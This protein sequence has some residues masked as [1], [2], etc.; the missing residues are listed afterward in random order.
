MHDANDDY[1]V[2]IFLAD[3][4]SETKFIRELAI[5]QLYHHIEA[6]RVREVLENV[7]KN[8]TDPFLKGMISSLLAMST[9]EITPDP[10]AA[11][12]VVD[13]ES[14][15]IRWRNR[16]LH[17]I[18]DLLPQID[19]LPA[20]QHAT[21]LL[22]LINDENEPTRLIPMF[23]LSGEL[24]RKPEII[25]ALAKKLYSSDY[26]FVIRLISFLAENGKNY[27]VKALPKLLKHKNFMVRAESIRFLFKISKKHALRLLEELIF[28]NEASRKSAATL[29]LLFPF[30]DIQHIAM[31]LIDSGAL[32][33]PSL[34]KLL[35]HLVANNPDADF[36]KRLTVAEVLRNDEIPEIEKLRK[37]AAE[38]LQLAGIIEG[39]VNEF[40]INSRKRISDYIKKR[41]GINI[42]VEEKAKEP[43]VTL[44]QQPQ[45]EESKAVNLPDKSEQPET[46][47]AK[48]EA[49]TSPSLPGK[50]NADAKKLA[51]MLLQADLSQDDKVMLRRLLL[52]EQTENIDDLILKVLARFKPADSQ[53]IKWLEN[54]LE[55]LQPNDALLAIK[56][57]SEI[58]PARITP[59]LP[60]LS[61][62]D[63]EMIAT[64]A[65]RLFK[66]HNLKGLLKQINSWLQEDSERSWKSALTAL[67]QLKIEI[68]REILLKIFKTT[69]RNSLIKFFAPVFILSPDHMTLYELELLAAE[70]RGNK[71]ELITEIT[72]E[73]KEVLGIT[74]AKN[75]EDSG[76]AALISAGIHIKWDEFKQGLEKIRYISNNQ[77]VF[78]TLTEFA[79]KH[80]IKGL[81]LAFVIFAYL[82]WPDTSISN[83]P[84][85]TDHGIKQTFQINQTIPQLKVGDHK[86]F[87]LESYD[88]INRSWRATGLDGQ[89]YRLKLPIPGD[90]TAGFKGDFKILYFTITKLGYPVV[91]CELVAKSK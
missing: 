58:N 37:E 69:S 13:K 30:E 47:K 36:F 79:R 20:D 54:S 49:K 7:E 29:L 42:V 18:K 61:V 72:S 86:I 51:E 43:P 17:H 26:I 81:L 31:S 34:N 6:P 32:Q 78:D 16:E 45:P 66:K 44:P 59:H 53:A 70:S 38:A 24:V 23:S 77:L 8:E 83:A 89:V 73:L 28:A 91:T 57:L 75:S 62:S 74:S 3:L 10:P 84:D 63:N 80:M 71:H 65:I 87:K 25:E 82:F 39:N 46:E 55:K 88:P 11:N 64:Q 19:S 12:G 1:L 27:L 56:L 22:E 2:E 33:D 9:S 85:A 60:V 50:D 4:K 21:T 14:L 48:P 52:S 90:F 68:S 41:A 35:T 76:T 15:L 67:L 40:C 5:T